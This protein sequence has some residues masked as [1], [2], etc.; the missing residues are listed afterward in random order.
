MS[1]MEAI[2]VHFVSPIPHGSYMQY[3]QCF[4]V[5]IMDMKTGLFL[6]IDSI[7]FLT[8]LLLSNPAGMS[9]NPTIQAGRIRV[10]L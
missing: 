10:D 5:P 1:Q 6:P 9:L 2:L 7:L 8:T 4:V 3:Y